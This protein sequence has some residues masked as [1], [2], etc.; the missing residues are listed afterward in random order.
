MPV[1]SGCAGL[2]MNWPGMN[3]ARCCSPNGVPNVVRLWIDDGKIVSVGCSIADASVTGRENTALK[4]GVSDESSPVTTMPCA[5][6]PFVE[7][8]RST[9]NSGSIGRPDVAFAPPSLV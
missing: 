1:P 7:A 5:F 2:E 8:G 6:L 4:F 9:P 3:I